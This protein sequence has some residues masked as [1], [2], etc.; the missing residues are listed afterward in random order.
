LPGAL[1]LA[2]FGGWAGSGGG[3]PRLRMWAPHASFVLLGWGFSFRGHQRVRPIRFGAGVV[4]SLM[5]LGIDMERL[6]S[7]ETLGYHLPSR[8]ARLGS[9]LLPFL[10]MLPFRDAV[11]DF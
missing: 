8:V 2:F 7:V 1:T 11:I 6:P 9:S 5:G 4:P 3:W 10:F